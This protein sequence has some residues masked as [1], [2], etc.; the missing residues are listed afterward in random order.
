MHEAVTTYLSDTSNV[1][2]SVHNDRLYGMTEDEIISKIGEATDQN[3]LK[4]ITAI[5]RV[6][7][8]SIKRSQALKRF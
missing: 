5:C 4:R 8:M 7:C 6:I 2:D 1:A 3:A